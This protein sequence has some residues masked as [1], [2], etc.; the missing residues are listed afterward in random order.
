MRA[1][2]GLVFGGVWF[3]VFGGRWR[4]LGLSLGFTGSGLRG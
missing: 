2:A 3:L 1:S 4:V